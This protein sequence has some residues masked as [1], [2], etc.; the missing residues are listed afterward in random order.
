RPR[1]QVRLVDLLAVDLDMAFLV[2]RDPVA[3]EADDAL[4]EVLDATGLRLGWRLEHDDVAAMDGVQ[5][6]AE[7]VDEHAVTDLERGDHRLRRDVEGLEEERL[8]DERDDDRDR[9]ED[10]PFG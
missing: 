6:V 7:L 5:V 9:E 8:D 3:R 4:D 1:R 2:R 10:D